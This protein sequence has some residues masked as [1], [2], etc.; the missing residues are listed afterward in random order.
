MSPLVLQRINFHLMHKSV[1][2]QQPLSR[3]ALTVVLFVLSI[4]ALSL[5]ASDVSA[6][7]DPAP[8]E[9]VQTIVPSSGQAKLAQSQQDTTVAVSENEA[10][11][12]AFDVLSAQA[13]M[14]RLATTTKQVA[15]EIAFVVSSPNREVMPYVWRHAILDTGDSAEQLS[16][17]NGPGYEQIRINNRVSIFEP[18]FS[19]YSINAKAIDGP[20]PMAFIHSTDIVNASYEVL[21]MGRNRISG[22]MAQQL[23]IVSKD[24]SRYGYHL[25]LDEQTGLLL[26]LNMY[27]LDGSLLEQI[28]VTQL[29]ISDDVKN[30]FDN[31]QIEQLPPLAVAGSQGMQKLSW[32]VAYRPVGMQIL[33]Q[34]L[35]RLSIT[36]DPAEYMMLSDGLVD[37]SIYVMAANDAIQNDISVTTDTTTVVSISD[38]RAQVTVVGEIPVATANKIANSI[39]LVKAPS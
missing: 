8:A 3:L 32:T 11:P 18:G 35:H 12:P 26:K 30:Y 5:S 29:I 19:P 23:R 14:N 9:P 2:N 37:V 13:W 10:S 17:L 1:F 36:G 22:R 20:V 24:K 39:V 6:Q 15:F 38:G 4:G 27:N 25:W 34:N 16:L 7:T 33:K 31:I 21:L 28:L